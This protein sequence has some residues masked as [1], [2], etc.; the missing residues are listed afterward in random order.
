MEW[1]LLAGVILALF[2][3]ARRP[4]R[5]VVVLRQTPDPMLRLMPTHAHAGRT[6]DALDAA[7]AVLR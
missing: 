1:M 7:T 3:L 2:F 4:R 5:P 6:R